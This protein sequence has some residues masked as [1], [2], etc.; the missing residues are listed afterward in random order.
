[1]YVYDSI[2]TVY[3]RLCT[4]MTIVMSFTVLDSHKPNSATTSAHALDYW[5]DI[6]SFCADDD[7]VTLTNHVHFFYFSLQLIVVFCAGHTNLCDEDMH[8]G[9]VGTDGRPTR[10]R[11]SK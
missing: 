6:V 7:S 11:I 2:N 8:P 5:H 4:L 9:L 3:V 1:M 10:H